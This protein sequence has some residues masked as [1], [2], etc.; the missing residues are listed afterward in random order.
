MDMQCDRQ[1]LLVSYF[2]VLHVRSVQQSALTIVLIDL[3]T[4][5]NTNAQEHWSECIRFVET[6]R[7]L[8]RNCVFIWEDFWIRKRRIVESRLLALLGCAHRIPARLTAARRIDKEAAN[9]FLEQNHLNG[10]VMAKYK[11]GLFLPARYF[12]V[13][14]EALTPAGSGELLVAV[15]TF[16][17]PRI[18]NKDTQPLRSHELIRS[19]SL[20]NTNVVGGLDKLLQAFIRDKMPGDIMTYADMEWSAGKSY[21]RLG[22]EKISR[23]APETIC[24]DPVAMERSNP[25]A[26]QSSPRVNIRNMGSIKFVKTITPIPIQH[27]NEH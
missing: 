27:I 6:E 26:S 22:F 1:P 23:T 10:A 17:Y 7:G 21:A 5:T 18:F 14:S 24:L 25:S 20:L 4:W 13:L 2:H 16:S 19:A 3:D 8:G 15:A 9:A 11:Y 12:R